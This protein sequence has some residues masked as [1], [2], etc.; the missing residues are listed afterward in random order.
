MNKRGTGVIFCLIAG[1]LFC[2]RYISTAIFMSSVSSWDS[3]LFN[4][5]LSYIGM[6]L[7]I[8]SVL[9][10]IIGICYLLLSI[11]DKED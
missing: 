6:P 8:L 3:E 9:S 7:L 11:K 1:L 10:L 4:A 5:G 2:T